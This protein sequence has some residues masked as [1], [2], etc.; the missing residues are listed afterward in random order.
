[1]TEPQSFFL[2][3]PDLTRYMTQPDRT[4]QPDIHSIGRLTMPDVR[5]LTLP[6]GVRMVIYDGGEERVNRLTIA[7]A[8]GEAEESP[9]APAGLMTSM[10]LE[11]AGSLS[12]ADIADKLDYNGSWTSTGTHHHLT[13]RTFFSLNSHMSEVM[14]V[15]SDIVM[16]P[17]FPDHEVSV[18]REKEARM[19]EL[20]REK[21]SWHASHLLNTMLAGVGSLL[22]SELDPA[23]LREVTATSL[24]DAYYARL[25]PQALTAYLTGRITPEIEDMVGRALDV[26]SQAPYSPLPSLR[27]VTCGASAP[28]IRRIVRPGAVQSAVAAGIPSIGRQHPDY[29]ILRLAVVFLGGYFGSRLMSN[30]RE[31]KGYTYGIGASLYGYETAGFVKIQTE[32][33]RRY[34]AGVIDEIRGELIRMQDASTYTQEELLRCR[35]Y[36]MTTLCAQLDSPFAVMDYYQ[37]YDFI[38]APEGY[39][40]R[41]QAS[42]DAMNP[43]LLAE[44]SRRYLD[45][46]QLR[47]AVAGAD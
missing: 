10:T 40:E 1:M 46:N 3:T 4:K 15:I 7:L 29:E 31:D 38:G 36:M 22:A 34:V 33:D 14:P 42:I 13:Q 17:V 30:I 16:H 45:P 8:G 44:T 41:Q 35:S 43:D 24:C 37:N 2:I 27:P 28:E 11:G 19:A 47:I 32:C 12:G 26:A 21:V 5:R 9:S 25:H 6:S 18:G 20:Q 39:F 23:A